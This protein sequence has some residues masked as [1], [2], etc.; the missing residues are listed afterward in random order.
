MKL[1]EFLTELTW[2]HNRFAYYWVVSRGKEPELFPMELE[3]EEWEEQFA[4]WLDLGKP[5][6]CKKI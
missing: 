6:P 4:A 3:P 5:Y 2:N 1:A